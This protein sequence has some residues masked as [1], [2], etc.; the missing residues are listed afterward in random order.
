MVLRQKI[1]TQVGNQLEEAAST[2]GTNTQAE[3]AG[4]VHIAS[5]AHEASLRAAC[6]VMGSRIPDPGTGLAA[7]GHSSRLQKVKCGCIT[8]DGVMLHE[9]VPVGL[10][11]CETSSI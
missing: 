1:R 4:N 7:V 9:W 3:Q 5:Q 10:Q 8:V 2:A 11:A 6:T